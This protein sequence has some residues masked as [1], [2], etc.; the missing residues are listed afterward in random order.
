[1]PG[2]RPF[3]AAVELSTGPAW[4][5]MCELGMTA[6]LRTG[7][8]YGL[9]A[10][11][12]D[13]LRAQIQVVDVMTRKGLRQHPKSRKSH[14]VVPVDP[15]VLEGMSVLMRGR[16]RDALVFTAPEAGRSATDTS[17]TGSGI[18]L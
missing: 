8:M 13:W 10:H 6:G 18:R 4:R 3:Y 14:R 2:P 15:V 1:M 16:P 5:T 12:V 9:H 11:G 7:G 17:A